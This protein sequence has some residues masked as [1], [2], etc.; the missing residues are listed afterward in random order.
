MPA[1][2]DVAELLAEGLVGAGHGGG[3]QVRQ[4]PWQL[5]VAAAGKA[6]WT[7]CSF[8][9]HLKDAERREERVGKQN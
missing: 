2:K 5:S 4:E 8:E 9:Q 6:S 3:E 1:L 7:R